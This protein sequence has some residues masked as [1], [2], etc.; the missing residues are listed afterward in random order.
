MLQQRHLSL[1]ELAMYRNLPG[2]NKYNESKVIC[3][4]IK[5]S[6]L[7][8]CQMLRYWRDSL[9]SVTHENSEIYTK[10]V[11]KPLSHV[12]AVDNCIHMIKFSGRMPKIMHTHK[13]NFIT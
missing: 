8:Q 10:L 12:E 1:L 3:L 9:L 2:R 7:S 6:I 5:G 11:S 4:F 13:E